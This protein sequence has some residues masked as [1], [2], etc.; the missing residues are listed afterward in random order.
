[1][2]LLWL[3]TRDYNYARAKAGPEDGEGL[4]L[5]LRGRAADLTC[6]EGMK[7]QKAA[8]GDCSWDKSWRLQREMEGHNIYGTSTGAGAIRERRTGRL[9]AGGGGHLETGWGDRGKQSR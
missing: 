7:S 8:A 9:E 3:R 1:M 4:D 2:G 5:G 6:R